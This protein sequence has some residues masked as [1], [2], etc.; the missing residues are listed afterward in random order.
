ME[1]AHA[2][3]E[4]AFPER[5]LPERELNETGV[6]EME[7]ARTSGAGVLG[8][9][10]LLILTRWAMLALLLG[11]ATWGAS[12]AGLSTTKL[13]VITLLVFAAT[14]FFMHAWILAGGSIEPRVL[15][16]AS[17]ADVLIFGIIAPVF[18]PGITDAFIV[19]YTAQL[20]AALLLH[21][22]ATIAL[23]AMAVMLYANLASY[24]GAIPIDPFF[25]VALVSITGVAAIGHVRLDIEESRLGHLFI[26]RRLRTSQGEGGES[27]DS[28]GSPE[29][30]GS[31]QRPG[32]GYWPAALVAVAARWF[33]IGSSVV[34]VALL[35]STASALVVGIAMTVVLMAVNFA[36]H[37]RYLV[38][39]PAGAR[40]VHLAAVLDLAAIAFT[41][42]FWASELHAAPWALLFALL[43]PAL[44]GV[45]LTFRPRVALVY[46]GLAIGFYLGAALLSAGLDDPMIARAVI[47]RSI[48]L[49]ATVGVA[50]AFQRAPGGHDAP[51][52]HLD[53]PRSLGY[54]R[55]L[56]GAGEA[57]GAQ[58]PTESA[59]G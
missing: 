40:L 16:L 15:A 30:P 5:E 55:W 42:S 35:A 48:I 29:R 2:V 26:P 27:A 12:T 10:M 9:G 43:C 7:K 18:A 21:G 13:V 31:L 3:P 32:G 54:H 4:G 6:P 59:A 51:A 23:A 56:T 39:R 19:S 24:H 52:A 38:G 14:N 41:A 22:G 46:A 37:G 53:G 47:E 28:D 11:M 36:L 1:T 50:V 17:A 20:A 25:A 8:S 44:V 33:L 49:A 45:S 34:L 57:D 58:A